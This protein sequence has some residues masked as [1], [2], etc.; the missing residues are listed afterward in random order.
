MNVLQSHE[1]DPPAK[2]ANLLTSQNSCQI[3]IHMEDVNL[4]NNWGRVAI[5]GDVWW[6]DVHETGPCESTQGP[7]CI[8]ALWT[9]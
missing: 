1:N 5:G 8:Q 9:T 2:H 6:N 7:V 3:K 4:N